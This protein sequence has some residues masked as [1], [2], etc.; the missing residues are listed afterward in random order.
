MVAIAI[1]K[2]LAL[3]VVF[4]AGFVIGAWWGNRQGMKNGPE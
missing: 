2:V 3:S 4:G 1:A